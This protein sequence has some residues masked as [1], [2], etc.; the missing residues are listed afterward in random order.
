MLTA[1]DHP[2]ATLREGLNALAEGKP[3]PMPLKETR[4]DID[5]E[6][7]ISIIRTT[8]VFNNDYE[9]AIEAIFTFPVP[10]EGVLTALS[11]EIDG[12]KLSAIAKA[13]T[14]AREDYEEAVS[15]GKMAILHEEPL[16]GLHMLSIGQLASGKAVRIDTEMVMPLSIADK[17]PFLKI[18]LVVGEIYGSSPFLPADNIKAVDGLDLEGTIH[19]N[20]EHGRV[21]LADG[22][23]LVNDQ[24]IKLDRHLYLQFPDQ[25]FGTLKGI[26]A[27]GR[28]V[29][30]SLAK[31]ETT[32]TAIDISILVDHS[33]STGGRLGRGSVHSAIRKGLNTIA[34]ELTNDDLI[35]LW[36]FDDEARFVGNTRG[37]DLKTLSKRL[38]G[39]EGG[40]ELGK[41]VEAVIQRDPKPILVL[42]DGQTYAHEVEMA[43]KA[44]FAI[45]AIL[46]GEGS[47]D[48]MIGHL[49]AQTG[50]QVISTYQDDVAGALKAVLPALRATHS[51]LS[52]AIDNGKP[53]SLR[54]TR[55]GIS[56][57]VAW[58]DIETPRMS[59]AIGRYAASLTLAL[60][61]EEAATSLAI[62]HGLTS[63]LT[64]LILIDDAGE[65][66]EGLP[67]TVKVPIASAAAHYSIGMP[68]LDHL[69]SRQ[70]TSQHAQISVAMFEASTRIYPSILDEGLD[71]DWSTVSLLSTIDIGSLPDF[72]RARVEKLIHEK[73]VFELARLCNMSV[74]AIAI[75]LVAVQD[76]DQD[77]NAGRFIRQQNLPADVYYKIEHWTLA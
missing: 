35:A 47:L 73:E 24:T 32:K 2:I 12:R 62:V 54:A 46:V 51:C 22:S 75:L 68:V 17:I 66:V 19:V 15:K 45:H 37:K 64:S 26:D 1:F 25:K 23:N 28:D 65:A 16:R 56:L 27:W 36:E 59:D 9:R 69:Y 10:F 4:F 48:A 5:V 55:G 50:G 71:G 11:A 31:H 13:K 61:E 33:G 30:L 58:S 7:G 41:A 3:E 74:E 43:K 34:E 77:R 67:K 63:H 39:P 21:L 40:T 52:G 70:L 6:N 44:G 72:I 42:T 20:A 76:R 57:E 14:E 29:M 49:A 60:L 53:S 18:P 38:S 8:R